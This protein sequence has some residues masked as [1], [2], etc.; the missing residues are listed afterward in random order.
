MQIG[1]FAKICNTKISVLRFYDK[2][3][4][5]Q[6]IY[7]DPFTGYRYYGKEQIAEYLKITT[8]KKAGFTLPEIK[9]ILAE[10]RNSEAILDMFR[11]KKAELEEIILNLDAAEKTVVGAEQLMKITVVDIEGKIKVR[12]CRTKAEEWADVFA[13]VD[14]AIQAEG[15]QRTSGYKMLSD[16]ETV[17]TVVKL[18]GEE[19][20]PHEN[21]DLPFVNDDT[22]IGKWEILGEY[23]VR[24][25]F[26][27]KSICPTQTEKGRILYFLP[28][29]ERYW[30]YGWT[31]GKLLVDDGYA[32]TVNTY[33]TEV[34]DDNYY[35]FVDL[36]SYHYRH[37]GE[38][39]VLVLHRLDNKVYREEDIRKKDKIDLPFCPDENILGCWHAVAFCEHKEDFDPAL[40]DEENKLYFSKVEF[41]PNGRVV[42][43]YG[44]GADIIDSENL[45]TWT[46]GY[47]LRKWNQTACAYDIREI[48]GEEYL[49]IEWKSGNYRWGGYETD[50]YVFIRE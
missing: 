14:K 2:A 35:M 12:A 36:K 38:T 18:K 4:L 49:F 42:S 32:T 24:E 25:D 40:C 1:E 33:S 37:G 47:L 28:D 41:Y 5:L 23:A 15:Y 31:K 39:T 13:G 9:R 34:I 10:R 16:D 29:G 7:T 46:R 8:L 43:F 19:S 20:I 48:D 50:Y 11:K 22:V 21:I 45:Q 30:S 27:P 3:G 17:C 6:P 26:D 44:H